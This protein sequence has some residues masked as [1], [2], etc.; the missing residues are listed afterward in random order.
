MNNLININF[1]PFKGELI[2]DWH[3]PLSKSVGNRLLMIWAFSDLNETLHTDEVAQWPEDMQQLLA[4]IQQK[5]IYPTE[6]INLGNGGTTFRF[7]IPYLASKKDDSRIFISNQLAERPHQDLWE[8]LQQ[9]GVAVIWNKSAKELLVKGNC[10][11]GGEVHG[12]STLSSQY[13]S[14]LLLAAPF[15]EKG[16]NLHLPMNLPSKSFADLTVDL[17]KKTGY[18]IQELQNEWKV[19]FQ[20]LVKPNLNH[21]WQK[22][23][24]GASF[25][26]LCIWLYPGSSLQI[27]D[28]KI[29]TLQ[30]DEMVRL[31][32]EELGVT[33][34]QA[35]DGILITC[36]KDANTILANPIVW[37]VSQCPDLAPVLAMALRFSHN[38]GSLVGLQSLSIKESNRF[39]GICQWLEEISPGN[40]SAI[41]SGITIYP[42]SIFKE[43]I[44]FKSH[45]DHRMA[46]VS[47]ILALKLGGSLDEGACVKK[48]FPGF[49][50]NLLQLVPEEQIIFEP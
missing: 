30:P 11:I 35:S 10:L 23:W 34:T 16:L 32:F 36:P 37:N 13:Y 42:S 25:A 22:D 12:N 3:V 28:L 24:A 15:M 48:S 50:D 44:A 20:P 19:S 6:N 18:Q 47:A 31:F 45:Q 41:Q 33:T 29:G 38:G 9:I 26:Y 5:E 2:G 43:N 4:A 49:W 14:A 1:I 7:L 17:M 27:P 39:H 46:M 8:M 40:W 21:L